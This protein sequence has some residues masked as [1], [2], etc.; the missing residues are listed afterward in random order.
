MVAMEEVKR[1]ILRELDLLAARDRGQLVAER[2][3][4]FRSLGVIP[5]RFPRA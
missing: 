2:R 1:T 3:A 5:D 4:K